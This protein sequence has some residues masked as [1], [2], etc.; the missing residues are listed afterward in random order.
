ML[1]HLIFGNWGLFLQYSRPHLKSGEEKAQGRPYSTLQL[2]ERRLWQ[3]GCQALLPGSSDRVRGN[4]LR[5]RWGAGWGVVQV[6]YWKQILLRKFFS[7]WHGLPRE[8]VES[9][10]LEVFKK[11]VD[12]A[13][14]NMVSGHGGDGLTVGLNDH[15]DLFQP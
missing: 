5:L 2:P 8:V 3:G 15:T 12:V 13:L 1:S 14:G 9:L 7:H 4:G 11:H 6:R 10:S